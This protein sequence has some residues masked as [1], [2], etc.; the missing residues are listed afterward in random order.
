MNMRNCCF[1][2]A[3]TFTFFSRCVREE[4][5]Q[6]S[7]NLSIVPRDNVVKQLL[8]FEVEIYAHR[9]DKTFAVARQ[10]FTFRQR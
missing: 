9:I 7:R 2:I 8:V 1:F 4:R 10:Q 3:L 5:S 6:P